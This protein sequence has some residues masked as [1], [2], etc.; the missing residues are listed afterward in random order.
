MKMYIFIFFTLFSCKLFGFSEVVFKEYL[1][2]ESRGFLKKNN[3]AGLAVYALKK[4]P[5]VDKIFEKTLC[6]GQARKSRAIALTESTLFRLGSLSKLFTALLVLK[7]VNEGKIEIQKSITEYIPKSFPIPT[8]NG[9]APSV[10]ELACEISSLPLVPTIPMNTQTASFLDV[11]NYF[12]TYKLPRAC[13][14]KYEPSDL[15][16]S[17]LA[18]ALSSVFKKSISECFKEEIF[19]FLELEETFYAPPLSKIAKCATGHQGLLEVPDIA[20]DRETSFFRP[21]RGL[22][23]CIDDMKKLVKCLLREERI[24]RAIVFK[25]MSKPEYVFPDHPLKKVSVGWKISPLSSLNLLQVY[26]Q[27]T[28]GDGFSHFI[29]VI[30]ETKAAVV[31]LSNSEY[32]V[33]E[34]GFKYLRALME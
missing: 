32:A 2:E 22:F 20:F 4:V 31:I 24:D 19:S 15:G 18:F 30:P 29:G 8:Y 28:Q 21:S 3:G 25:G 16:Y 5:E 10:V 23:S 9:K 11:K 14:S 7:A 33:E 34:L 17:L 27:S 12:S 26:F 6:L 1:E 13:G